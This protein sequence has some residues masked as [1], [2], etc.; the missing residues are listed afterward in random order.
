MYMI[1]VD[2]FNARFAGTFHVINQGIVA[3]TCLVW[4]HGHLGL[5]SNRCVWS[6][7]Q[8]R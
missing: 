4:C 2:A 8:E 1:P 6:I 3:I 7:K 5:N